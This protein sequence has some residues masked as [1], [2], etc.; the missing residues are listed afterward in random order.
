[1][2][3]SGASLDIGIG[4]PL[5]AAGQA[6]LKLQTLILAAWQAGN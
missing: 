3:V 2:S 6:D 1:M 5:L 4:Q